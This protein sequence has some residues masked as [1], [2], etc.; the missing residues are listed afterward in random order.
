[1]P[2][3]ITDKKTVNNIENITY[4]DLTSS[5]D[6]NMD[7]Y[8]RVE[9]TTNKNTQYVTNSVHLRDKGFI[10]DLQVLNFFMVFSLIVVLVLYFS[11]NYVPYIF[12][13][14]NP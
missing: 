13:N 14:L 9:V 5:H 8:V 7:K 4:N 2:R 11:I 6:E 1:M 3:R 10:I 12:E